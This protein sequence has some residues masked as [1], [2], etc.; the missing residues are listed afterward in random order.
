LVVA[1][2]G[3]VLAGGTWLGGCVRGPRLVSESHAAYNDALRVRLD[4]ELLLNLVRL[5]YRDRPLFLQVSSV[6]ARFERESSLDLS[7]G[8]NA[9]AS[10]GSAPSISGGAGV[11]LGFAE[12][13][14]VTFTPL[15]GEDFAER[16]L[17]PIDLETLA[18]LQRSGWSIERVMRLTVQ[19][20]NGLDNAAGASGPTPARSPVFREFIEASHALKQL[21][22]QRAVVIGS[23]TSA[24]S[25]SEP[26]P[27]KAVLP[28]DVL[29]AAGAGQR[30]ESVPGQPRTQP[31][32]T[33][34][35]AQEAQSGSMVVLRSE[36]SR[37]VLR[38]GATTT[39]APETQRLRQMLGLDPEARS[40]DLEPAA[41]A[42]ED[43]LGPAGERR[44]IV[45]VTRSL[46]GVLFFLCHAVEIPDAHAQAGVVTVTRDASGQP[47]EWSE[48]TEGLMRIRSSLDRPDDAAIAVPY[49]GYWFSIA[50]DDLDSKSTFA[51]L[52]QLYALQAGAPVAGGAPVP[53]IPVGG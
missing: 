33:D 44:R 16:L 13:P 22:D 38:I 40:Y 8:V 30:F 20:M 51:L 41:G 1:V 32:E 50:D 18:L 26:L 34:G 2:A 53:T 25:L 17:R 39:E 48:V 43:V 7:A 11:G 15:Q 31:P 12:Q 28:A 24:A 23:E 29:V 35:D 9:D 52:T 45:V 3:L 4:E 10:S 36:Q 42:V 37:F 14:T 21:Q 47:F 19:R 6:I 27:A 49:R 5:R 46:L